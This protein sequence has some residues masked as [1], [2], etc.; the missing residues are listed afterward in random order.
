MRLDSRTG[1]P[2]AGHADDDGRDRDDHEHHQDRLT[3]DKGDKLTDPGKHTGEE[4]SDISDEGTESI[5]SS[6]KSFL[7]SHRLLIKRSVIATTAV[8]IS[9]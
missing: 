7:L 1:D 2:A 4:A 9:G 8:Q 3:G 5:S 6:L